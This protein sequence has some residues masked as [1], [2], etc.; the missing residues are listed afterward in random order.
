MQR[1]ISSTALTVRLVGLLSCLPWHPSYAAN[2]TFSPNLLFQEIYS[3]NLGLAAPGSG[4]VAGLASSVS[5][6]FGVS[7]QSAFGNLNLNYR[8]QGVY[9][10][11]GDNAITAYNQLQ[12]NANHTLVPNKFFLNAS[13]SIS[14]QN[15]SSTQVATDNVS[16]NN[17][18]SVNTFSLSPT[19]TP[20]FGNYAYGR[21]GGNFSSFS[22]NNSSLT[23]NT[24]V[25]GAGSGISDAITYGENVQ[26]NSGTAFKSIGWN[27]MFNNLETQQLSASNI[28][29]QNATATIRDYLSKT[30]NFFVQGGYA[31]NDL[32]SSL[33]GGSANNGVFYTVGAQWNPSRI[34]SFEVGGGNNSHVTFSFN[35]MRR[36]RWVTT[37]NDNAIGLNPGQTW[38]TAL[39]YQA[40]RATWSLTH[41]NSTTTT[42]ALLL[43]KGSVIYNTGPNQYVQF[44]IL[45]PTLGNQVYLTQTWNL[46]VSFYMG[47]SN[48]MVGAFNQSRQ[49]QNVGNNA[50][51]S[52]LTENV[53]GINASWNWQF[54]PKTSTYVVP[55]WQ[56]ISGQFSEYD[57]SVGLNRSFTSRINGRLEFRH[58]NQSS[59]I[60]TT[61]A[62]IPANGSFEENRATASLFVRF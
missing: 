61:T 45:I 8:L 24:T 12:F 1:R 11:A 5:P 25:S 35:P 58:I 28:R 26:L 54:T 60:A 27:L 40:R 62:T 30:V 44:P 4:A 10:G 31:N 59:S 49:S 19:W 43:E 16:S 37:F 39:T 57:V 48:F 56:Q 42:Q 50:V 7:R 41:N 6:G 47:K 29:Y 55:R 15:L 46:S 18:T 23:N 33:A 53:N 32:Q 3:D 34:Y 52:N 2:W 9:N 51:N 21:I 22:T 17:R 13:S 38:Q 20:H 14:Q 36:L